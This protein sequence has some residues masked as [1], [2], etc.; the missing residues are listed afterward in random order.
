MS[1]SDARTWNWSA[2]ALFLLV[3]LIAISFFFSP[4]TGDVSI[5]ETWMRAI[6]TYGLIGSFAH[7]GTDYPPLALVIL[8]GV[9]RGAE[10]FGTTQFLILKCSLLL[11]LFATSACF[12]WFTRS[13]LLTASL[14]L[15][16]ILNSVAL[17][18]LDIFFAPFLIAG[19]FLLQR[20]RLSIG[21][22]FFAISCAIK[23]Q[24][25][26]IAP[27]V[28]LYI[29]SAADR[30]VSGTARI[31]SQIAPFAISALL[32]LIPMFVV[33]GAP[34]MLDSFKRALT[35]HKF[36]SG[37]A[38]NLGWIQTWALHLLNPER[39]G[40]LLPD[41]AI[42]AAIVRDPFVVW[43][44]KV[45]FYLSY[46]AILFAF[47]R[48]TKTFERLIIYSALGYMAYF[49]FNTGVHENHLFLV[50]CLAWMLVFFERGQLVRCI[51]LTIAA[52]ANLFLFFGAFGE[53]VSPV[54]AG[55]D[56]T[57]L[58]AVANLCL[59]TGWLIHTAMTDGIDLW[60][61]KIPARRA[62]AA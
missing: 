18:Y 44:N 13:L 32:L 40:G 48:Q 61:V 59:F 19:F 22:L 17:G 51:N 58:F 42:D 60:F 12:Y 49:S 3:N 1:A 54:I 41:G 9:V 20:Q 55:V 62:P 47:V 27:F 29:L 8:A 28:C 50:S 37:Y 43:P 11:F 4:G 46:S 56:I 45:L 38:L 24:P 33:F 23:W 2:I 31:K 14:E 16:L 57:L 21:F 35:Y 34:A 39:Y 7:T 10:A 30:R 26:I 15:S 36:L 25:L 52:N 53:R 6:S 5:W